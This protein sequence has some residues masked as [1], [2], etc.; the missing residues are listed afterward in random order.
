[1]TKEELLKKLDSSDKNEIREAILKLEKFSDEDVVK[2]IVDT[3]LKVKSK[4]VLEAA[5]ETLMTIEN[6]KV[7]AE[8]VI[9]L[10]FSDSPKIRHSGIE[11]I[12]SCGN[13]ALKPIREKL[14]FHNDFNIRK[15]ALD[16]LKEIKTEEALD[17]IKLLI[18]DDNPNVK[19]S[20]VEFL[21]E[22]TNL[23]DKVV[24]ILLEFIKHE[25]FESLYGVTAVASTIIYGHFFDKKFIPLIKEKLKDID[26]DNIKHWLYKILIYLGDKDIIEEARENAKK[27]GMEKVIEND[28]TMSK[29]DL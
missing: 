6:K 12:I 16:I 15:H 18:N 25:K 28:I 20:A 14:I 9:N 2:K 1:M 4:K 7:I 19:Y 29:I 24:D 21:M 11:I 22:Y 23:K 27:V 5:V 17:L 13:E 10:I 3:I 8:N 26:D